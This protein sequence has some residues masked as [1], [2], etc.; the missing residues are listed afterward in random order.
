MTIFK[1]STLTLATCLSLLGCDDDSLQDTDTQETSSL[2]VDSSSIPVA[3]IAFAEA[4]GVSVR[5]FTF[6]TEDN[7]PVSLGYSV[8][9]EPGA[10]QA[11]ESI[12]DQGATTLEL[13]LHLSP[14]SEP[15]NELIRDHKQATERQGRNS[16]IQTYSTFRGF[17]SITVEEACQGNESDF[18]SFLSEVLA[19]GYA[20]KI[21]S[22]WGSRR[23]N[24]VYHSNQDSSKNVRIRVCNPFPSQV[25]CG[26]DRFSATPFAISS[27]GSV[28]TAPTQLVPS[29][30]MFRFFWSGQ[31]NDRDYGVWVQNPQY[32]PASAGWQTCDLGNPNCQALTVWLAVGPQ[33]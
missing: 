8:T 11:V 23:V 27:N 33:D 7:E 1:R 26:F 9:G 28:G 10:V 20:Y 12:I 3:E 30:H 32:L 15:A 19:P 5:F 17:E 4:N 16:A 18:F 21:D 14:D 29:C 24:T 25:N 22:I 31:V 2:P 6:P 13:F